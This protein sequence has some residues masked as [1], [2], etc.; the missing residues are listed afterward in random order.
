LSK[1]KETLI[2]AGKALYGGRWQTD[3]SRDLGLSDGRRVRQWISGDR[4]IPGKV[5]GQLKEL[6]DKRSSMIIGVLVEV[7]EMSSGGK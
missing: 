2:N 6:L 3:L 1:A 7:D 5:W 4:P